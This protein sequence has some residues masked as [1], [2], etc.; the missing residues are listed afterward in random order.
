MVSD[1]VANRTKCPLCEQIVVCG[2]EAAVCPS[3]GCKLR[4]REGQAYA[5][6]KRGRF[7]YPKII[8]CGVFILMLIL[9]LM[10]KGKNSP[11]PIGLGLSGGLLPLLVAVEGL[12][13]GN[14]ELKG[15][16]VTWKRNPITFI[17]YVLLD[18][19]L[20]LLIFGALLKNLR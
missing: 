9:T 15:S 1:V 19:A 8:L 6:S 18:C 5:V 3:C 14:I 17:I 4:F 11:F 10:N 20:S 16:V 2:N 13:E 12:I 7:Y